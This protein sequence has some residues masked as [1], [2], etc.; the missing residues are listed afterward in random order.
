MLPLLTEE[1]CRIERCVGP[2]WGAGEVGIIESYTTNG[3]SRYAIGQLLA[4]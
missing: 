1:F 3:L 4:L 2:V